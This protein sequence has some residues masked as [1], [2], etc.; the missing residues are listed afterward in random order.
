MS[1]IDICFLQGWVFLNIDSDKTPVKTSKRYRLNRSPT[2]SVTAGISPIILFFYFGIQPDKAGVNYSSVK[3][4]DL[5]STFRKNNNKSKFL[6]RLVTSTY[7][8]SICLSLRDT[9]KMNFKTI[10]ISIWS[11]HSTDLRTRVIYLLCVF[12]FL[13]YLYLYAKFMFFIENRKCSLRQ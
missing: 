1:L 6:R 5:N 10:I 12:M 2:V 13:Q 9:P 3:F 8:F 11:L 4:W 7:C